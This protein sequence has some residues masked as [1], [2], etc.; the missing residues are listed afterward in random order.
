MIKKKLWQDKLRS[1][2]AVIAK[3]NTSK[4]LVGRFWFKKNEKNFYSILII[5]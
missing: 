3:K 4:S 5:K 2:R 1:S